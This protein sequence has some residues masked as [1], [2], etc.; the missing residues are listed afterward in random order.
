MAWCSG[1]LRLCGFG[2]AMRRV[3]NSMEGWYSVVSANDAEGNVCTR[4]RGGS[5]KK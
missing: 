1:R 5:D 3:F 4:Y 2:H